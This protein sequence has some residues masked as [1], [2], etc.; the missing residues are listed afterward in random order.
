M[1]SFVP[2]ILRVSTRPP[3]KCLPVWWVGYFSCVPVQAS[4]SKCMRRNSVSFWAE[5]LFRCHR[6][7]LLSET[8][9]FSVTW[10][11]SVPL[12]ELSAY[13]PHSSPDPFGA[14]LP[15][16][17]GIFPPLRGGGRFMNR[18][19]GVTRTRPQICH[20]ERPKGVEGS[21]HYRYCDAQIGAKILRLRASPTLRMTDVY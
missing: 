21:S 9:S 3:W 13:R 14:T 15:P 6:P 18:P 4:Y 1:P 8:M 16:G 17:E 2:S 19:Y 20:P 12:Y 7:R 5:T 10:W 11:R